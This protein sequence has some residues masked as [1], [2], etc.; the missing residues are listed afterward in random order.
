[1]SG[2]CSSERVGPYNPG[3]QAQQA[4]LKTELEDPD[5]AGQEVQDLDSQEQAHE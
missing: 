3:F 1:V 4:V 2:F 5:Q